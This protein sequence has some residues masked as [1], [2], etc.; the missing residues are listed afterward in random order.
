MGTDD[1][2]KS[3]GPFTLRQHL[4][5]LQ[6][7]KKAQQTNFSPLS[8]HAVLSKSAKSHQKASV[9]KQE[10]KKRERLPK[11]ND[12]SKTIRKKKNEN[13]RI[14]NIFASL[15]YEQL[16][17]EDVFDNIVSGIQHADYT[18]LRTKK[19]CDQFL[20]S[21][22]ERFVPS[23]G[24]VPSRIVKSSVDLEALDCVDA[25]EC[26]V[27]DQEIESTEG[28]LDAEVQQFNQ[29]EKSKPSE[30][31][32]VTALRKSTRNKKTRPPPA[33]NRS[34]ISAGKRRNM[35]KHDYNYTQTDT[36]PIG[37]KATTSRTYHTNA[38]ETNFGADSAYR[39]Q[40][41]E[42]A[43]SMGSL[44]NIGNSCYMNSVIYTLRYTPLFLHNLHHLVSD[45][46][47]IFNQKEN[48]QKMKSASLGRNVNGLQGA[49]ARSYSSKDLVSLGSSSSSTVSL[50]TLDIVKT[51]Q[52]KASEKL[53]ELF[54]CLSK[55]ENE[56]TNEPYQQSDIFLKAIQDVNPIFEGNQQQDAH[57]FLM[58]I[59]DSIRETCQS[60]K[61]NVIEHPEIIMQGYIF[62]IYVQSSLN[63]FYF[64]FFFYFTSPP[65]IIVQLIKSIDK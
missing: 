3:S 31:I 36:L 23:I 51:A 8:F 50:P 35:S 65:D 63:R 12:N 15:T 54:Q 32:N 26:V 43:A 58:C 41:Q 29:N 48:Q 39:Q 25:A 20:N 7:H 40:M 53:H 28:N 34:Q 14:Q 64:F 18:K 4:N 52:Q 27:I 2:T 62:S 55:N 38:I 10:S 33:H 9:E 21:L 47:Q 5:I 16:T 1:D 42:V 30:S 6:D 60:L 24:K 57:E 45:F 59:L 11:L 19:Q 46:A 22:C 17:E 44:C 56:D 37:G 61:K 13:P 49:N